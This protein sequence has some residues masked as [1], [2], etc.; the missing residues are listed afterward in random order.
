MSE[1]LVSVLITAYNREKYIAEAINSVLDS[2]YKNFEIIIV[3][4]GSSDMTVSIAEEYV[5]KDERVKLFVNPQNLGQFANR[6]KAASY[7]NGEYLKYLDSDDKISKDGLEKIMNV[8]L[9][10]PEAAF[11]SQSTNDVIGL[12]FPRESY[13]N[14]Y[15]KGNKLLYAG[16]S[17]VIFKTS[18]FKEVGGFSEIGGILS[19]TLLMLTIAAIYP[20][21]SLPANF[22]YWRVHD[23]RVTILQED[24]YSMVI[25]RNSI[26]NIILHSPEC[27]LTRRECNV[28]KQNQKSIF[29][30]KSFLIL[31]KIKSLRKYLHLLGI[32]NIASQD[33]L[34]A[35]T[36]NKT[37]EA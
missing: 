19:D 32:Q 27:P 11:G 2:T 12:T 17:G 7:A 16:P 30:R 3:D 4:D 24:E 33:F 34:I 1:P 9:Q 37:L 18:V 8:M 28:I 23:E 14:Y 15:F 10:Y 35:L 25:E 20:L 13:I 6:N 21:A 22:L 31:I 5:H 29:I 36:P 26:N